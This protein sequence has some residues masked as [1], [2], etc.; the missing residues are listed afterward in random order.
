MFEDDYTLHGDINF[1]RYF[2]KLDEYEMYREILWI[3]KTDGRLSDRKLCNT[4]IN[5]KSLIHTLW[6][7]NLGSSNIKSI[8][9]EVVNKITLL[10]KYIT[11]Q[12][13]EDYHGSDVYDDTIYTIEKELLDM[14]DIEKEYEKRY[15]YLKEKY[16]NN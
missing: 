7:S 3:I 5:L 1:F 10:E 9:F 15:D 16:A 12:F 8:L 11:K 14:I 6:R 4:S 13:D 2:S